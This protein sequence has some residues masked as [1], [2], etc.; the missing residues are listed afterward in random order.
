[1]TNT[2]C[3]GKQKCI[4]KI[5]YLNS[6]YCRIYYKICYRWKTLKTKNVH[7]IQFSDLASSSRGAKKAAK[8][9][10]M[11]RMVSSR[12]KLISFV[13]MQHSDVHASSYCVFSLRSLVDGHIRI[14]L[15]HTTHFVK[16]A[17]NFLS[18]LPFICKFFC[19]SFRRRRCSIVSFF[20]FTAK[21]CF[22][23]TV[24]NRL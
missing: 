1:M 3:D 13:Y 11:P 10:M 9:R 22:C 8:S 16:T 17:N 18:L 5:S 23:T 6:I 24:F 20:L 12:M 15:R 4:I 14:F 2:L 21:E 7:W 19:F